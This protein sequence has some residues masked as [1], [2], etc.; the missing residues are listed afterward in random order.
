MANSWP[1]FGHD[2]KQTFCSPD[3]VFSGTPTTLWSYTPFGVT[4][5]AFYTSLIADS[6]GVYSNYL[7]QAPYSG[8]SE[9]LSTA[10]SRVWIN[11]S[12]SLGGPEPGVNSACLTS[13]GGYL[14][15]ADGIR[16]LSATS[17]T[18]LQ[19][20]S[21][22]LWGTAFMDPGGSK[23]YMTNDYTNGDTISTFGIFVG[24]ALVSNPSSLLWR[25]LYYYTPRLANCLGT[26]NYYLYSMVLANNSIY[27][28]VKFLQNCTNFVENVG[29]VATD[30]GF[31]AYPTGIYVFDA[32]TGAQK[33]YVTTSGWGPKLAVGTYLISAEVALDNNSV[34]VKAY[35]ID[36]MTVIWTNTISEGVV[37]DLFTQNKNNQYHPTPVL[38][39]GLAII[40]TSTKITAYNQVTGAIV[41]TYNQPAPFISDYNLEV[42]GIVMVGAA[43]SN[44]LIVCQSDGLHLLNSTNGSEIWSGKPTGMSGV[45]ANPVI[46]G[47]TLY[48]TEHNVGGKVY[49]MQSQGGIPPTTD[50]TPPTAAIVSPVESEVVSGTFS[51]ISTFSDD[52]GVVRL[53]TYF[54]GSLVNTALYPTSPYLVNINSTSYQNG[55]Y[56]AYCQAFDAAGNSTT[57]TTVNFYISNIAIP[58]D[59]TP[60]VVRITA[61]TSTT[62]PSKGSIKIT[63]TAS[64]ASG[65]SAIN[66]LLDGVNIAQCSGVTTCTKSYP[67]SK[68]SS[69]THIITIEARDKVGN[70]GTASLTVTK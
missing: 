66:I 20:M 55:S 64:D 15:L 30:T 29:Y 34:V 43:G 58:I 60:P 33:K 45:P 48:V 13:D 21:Y 5:S 44:T 35:D 32:G 19:S 53:H 9:K 8:T 68:I 23:V 42:I 39:N 67:V 3:G 69:G 46:V 41:W 1:T 38:I 7:I 28:G 37:I 65:I 14:M 6:S 54:N 59:T 17:G 18:L 11:T 63:G 57:S 47:D 61:P 52:V 24:A 50:T 10:G 51:V 40:P 2:E 4:P 26:N 70:K 12:W 56:P 49:A 22:D 62:I 16:K 25:S 27:Y 36:T 31:V